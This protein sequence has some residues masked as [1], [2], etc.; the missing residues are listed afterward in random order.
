MPVF[1][2][3][4][5]DFDAG[6]DAAHHAILEMVGLCKRWRRKPLPS[7]DDEDMERLQTALR[8]KNCWRFNALTGQSGLSTLAP[9]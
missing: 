2:L 1:D 9:L 4:Y 7:F 6:G 3:M 8:E 5:S